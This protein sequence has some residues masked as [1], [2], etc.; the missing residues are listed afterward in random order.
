MELRKVKIG[1]VQ[2]PEVR[3]TARFNDEIWEQFQSSLKTT[4]QVTPIIVYETKE[5]L[6]LCDGLHRLIESKNS[7]E[8]E[9]FAAILPGDMAD[10]M[11]K[12]IMLDHLRGKTPVSEMI[13][14]IKF[15]WKELDLDSERIA[16]KT[17]LSRDYIEKLQKISELTPF[18]LEQIDQERIG[19]GHA[20]A[21]TKIKDPIRQET[22]CNQLLMYHWTI[23]EL[24]DFIRQ[25]E[26][27]V[28]EPSTETPSE[29]PQGPR[30]IQCNFCRQLYELSQ[31]ANPNTCVGCAGILHASISQAE[32][33]Y[34]EEQSA[35]KE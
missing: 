13:G 18:C 30:M 7:G 26:Q 21:L 1:E 24:E 25:V 33:E 31:I 11:T 35:A 19:V 29:E 28:P 17:G 2:I 9:I 27:L 8:T 5:G 4:G 23:R 15:L 6:V 10:V 3:V 14:V 22:V 20:S 34:R 16:E 32:R 12:N